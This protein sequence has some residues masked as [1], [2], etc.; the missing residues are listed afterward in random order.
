[1][2]ESTV[3][4]HEAFEKAFVLYPNPSDGEVYLSLDYAIQG[5]VNLSVTNSIGMQVYETELE[6]SQ[7]NSTVKLPLSQ[8]EKGV[9]LIQITTSELHAVKPLLINK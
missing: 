3:G 4:L 1:V 8:L 5:K 9:Y 2:L 6:A 7:L